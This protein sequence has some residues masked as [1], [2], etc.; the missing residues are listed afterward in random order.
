MERDRRFA[1]PWTEQR[2]LC[3]RTCHLPRRFPPSTERA[4]PPLLNPGLAFPAGLPRAL[5]AGRAPSRRGGPPAAHRGRRG[6]RRVPALRRGHGSGGLGGPSASAPREGPPA[7]PRPEGRR[8]A[9]LRA[10]RTGRGRG[11]A[12][13]PGSQPE[14]PLRGLGGRPV[15]RSPPWRRASPAWR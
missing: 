14:P 7:P 1:S 6:K 13:P 2:G 8:A 9:R 15:P 4:F 10:P 11:K 12:S 5:R 3:P